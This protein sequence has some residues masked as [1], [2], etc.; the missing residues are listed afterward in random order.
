MRR[1]DKK[2]RNMRTKLRIK[3]VEKKKMTETQN[4]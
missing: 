3:S 2:F 4:K 1:G